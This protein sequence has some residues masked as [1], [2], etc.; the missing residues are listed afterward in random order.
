MQFRVVKSGDNIFYYF[1]SYIDV[2]C[3]GDS[4]SEM[5][6]SVWNVIEKLIASEFHQNFTACSPKSTQ[7]YSIEIFELSL[8][9]SLSLSLPPRNFQSG[10]GFVKFHEKVDFDLVNIVICSIWLQMRNP[11]TRLRIVYMRIKNAI[12][13]FYHPQL[14]ESQIYTLLLNTFPCSFLWMHSDTCESIL[15]QMVRM[16]FI[17]GSKIIKVFERRIVDFDSM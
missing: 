12:P 13:W 14:Y 16:C 2:I 9:L 7:S 8:S 10:V 17:I 15:V 6:L 4:E 1:I 11:C 5:R 3:Y